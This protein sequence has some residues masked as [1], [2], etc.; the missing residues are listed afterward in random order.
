M[1]KLTATAAIMGAACAAAVS[2]THA[3]FD[4]RGAGWML[5]VAGE[6]PVLEASIAGR[7]LRAEWMHDAGVGA[8]L[9]G[10]SVGEELGPMRGD[11]C[12]ALRLSQTEAAS[13][14]L[15]AGARV[16]ALEPAG[17]FDGA[18]PLL[19]VRARTAIAPALDLGCMAGVVGGDRPVPELE[20]SLRAKLDRRWTL[21]MTAGWRGSQGDAWDGQ[22]MPSLSP[23]GVAFRIGI[24]AEF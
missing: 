15:L 17:G 24:S 14:D 2:G 9:D 22:P 16:S 12:A 3:D 10:F 23:E 13:L 7:G 20:A 5:E 1:R 4:V 11:A 19:A 21:D 8:R 6:A 18:D